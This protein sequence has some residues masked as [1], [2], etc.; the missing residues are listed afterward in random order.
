[1][2]EPAS[3]RLSRLL[4]LVPWLAA[5]DGTTLAA[6][7]EHFG[8][9]ERQLQEDLELLIVCGRPGY[10]PDQLVDI[11]FWDDDFEIHLDERIHVVDPQVLDLPLRLTHEEALTL[12]VA[13]RLLAQVPGVEGHDAIVSAAVKL[14]DATWA[15]EAARTIAVRT[16]VDEDVRAAVDAALDRQAA[17]AITYAASTRDE[18]TERI[19]EPRRVV[20][21][22]SVAYLEAFCHLAGALRTFR[23]DRVLTARVTDVPGTEAADPDPGVPGGPASPLVAVLDLDPGARWLVDVHGADV[24]QEGPDTMRV[25]LPLLSVDWGVRLVLSL[26]GQARVVEPDVL[27]DAVTAAA[28]AA[29]AAYSGQVP[30]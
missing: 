30:W 5:N 15:T 28:E 13:L 23:L 29:L 20:T 24:Q 8:V 25:A 21:V 1:M 14:E 9:T 19:V 17:L 7:A 27:A 16:G 4:A 3:T 10:G 22:D 12:L 11:Q 26:R 18:V 6:C 2:T